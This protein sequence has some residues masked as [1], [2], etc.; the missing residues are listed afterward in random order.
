MVASMPND[1]KKTVC[2]FILFLLK[3]TMVINTQIAA[4][5][6]ISKR[7]I[8]LDLLNSGK[9]ILSKKITPIKIN[10]IDRSSEIAFIIRPLIV[11][12]YCAFLHFS[13]SRLQVFPAVY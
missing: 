8:E 9:N 10:G 11:K 13:A 4:K 7:N 3:R 6:E 2:L 12:Y 5:H 1:S